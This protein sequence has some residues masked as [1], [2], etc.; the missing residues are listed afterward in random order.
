MRSQ[1]IHSVKWLGL[2]RLVGQGTAALMSVVVVRLL[3]PADYGVMAVALIFLGVILLLNE[4]GLGAALVQRETLERRE[5]EQVFGL[6]LVVNLMLYAAVY[7]TAPFIAV[8]FKEPRITPIIQ[9]VA[10]RLP[11]IALLVVPRAMLQREMRFQVKSM[12][13]LAGMVSA[14]SA[15]LVLAMLGY[16]VWAL[17]CGVLFGAVVEIMGMYVASGHWVRP[18]FSV[19][20]MRGQAVFGGYLTL[21]RL[22]WYTYTQSDAVIVGRL[23]GNESL[24]FYYVAKKFASLPLDVSGGIFTEVGFSAYSRIQH[25]RRRLREHYC[26]VARMASFFSVPVCFGISAVAPEAVPVVFGS[27]WVEV[28]LPLQFIALIT[29]LRQLN[30]LSTPALLAIGKPEVNVINLLIAMTI[31]PGAF[32]VGSQWGLTGVALAWSLA[33]PVYF[34]IMLARSLP[35]LGVPGNR[36]FGGIWPAFVAGGAMYGTVKLSR[37]ALQSTDAPLALTLAVYICVG[38]IAY[39]GAICLIRRTLVQE[40]LTLIKPGQRST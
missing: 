27:R 8:L 37:L 15:T 38:A 10:L 22:L 39:S 14:S 16:G 19:R 32:L 35:I 13:D 6:L 4:M 1:V 18:R 25:D 40:F 17:A 33:Y 11:L 7:Y 21:D 12:V 23:I 36:Y 20:G 2:A 26:K 5:I 31:M 28:I 29:P 24:G 34:L 3:E 9:L 30:S